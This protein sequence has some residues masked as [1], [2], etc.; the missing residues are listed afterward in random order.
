MSENN[1]VN[2]NEAM[3]SERNLSSQTRQLGMGLSAKLGGQISNNKTFT[4]K[5]GRQVNFVKRF[6]N[7]A[8]EIETLTQVHE[9]NGRNQDL[10][11][12]DESLTE[13]VETM[14]HGQLYEA[15]GV[16][17][18]GICFIL[19]GSRRRTAAILAKSSFVAY[20]TLDELTQSE[21]QY[22]SDISKLSKPLT[23]IEKGQ[24]YHSVKVREGF[25]SDLELA[26]YLSVSPALISRS[27]KCYSF[28]SELSL[29]FPLP[30]G[31]TSNNWKDIIPLI[32]KYEKT[33][34]LT[35][36]NGKIISE[37]LERVTAELQK[38]TQN[39]IAIENLKLLVNDLTN[40]KKKDKPESVVLFSEKKDRHTVEIVKKVNSQRKSTFLLSGVP[41]SKQKLIEKAIKEIMESE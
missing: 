37:N 19:D 40:K 23:L 28:P 39:N 24:Y 13:L 27:L 15:I 25:E 32:N 30:A 35:E 18:D 9:A 31:L 17:R 1:K 21:A 7:N 3:S 2:P 36:D 16:E 6:F 26:E 10:L 22:I 29:A 4:L 11:L 34:P 33:F 8:E 20:V 12:V 41:V 38:A 14:K 5:N